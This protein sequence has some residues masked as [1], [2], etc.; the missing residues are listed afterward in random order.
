MGI[1][2]GSHSAGGK[3]HYHDRGRRDKRYRVYEPTLGSDVRDD[4]RSD[5]QTCGAGP[6]KKMKLAGLLDPNPDP[7]AEREPESGAP[8]EA[9]CILLH[10]RSSVRSFQSKPTPVQ[11]VTS[12]P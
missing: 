9:V 8:R 12:H 5:C 2:C 3:D 6:D 1:Q 4:Q 7:E 10:C 11:D